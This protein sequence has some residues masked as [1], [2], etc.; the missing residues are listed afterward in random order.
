MSVAIQDK[1]G[2]YAATI[3]SAANLHIAASGLN[4]DRVWDDIAVLVL[5]NEIPEEINIVAAAQARNRGVRT[6]LNAAPY[7][8]LPPSLC[9]MI[10]VLVVN[11]V[12]AE[13]MGAGH[14]C[15]LASASRGSL[16]VLTR[17]SSLSS[18]TSTSRVAWA[19][20]RGA[21]SRLLNL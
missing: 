18:T 12:E 3:V 14:V 21:A 4:D 13:M 15:C 16:H 1:D 2:D 6:V 9:P 11:A 17:R 20:Q 10:D 7:R 19:S 8:A 5:Q